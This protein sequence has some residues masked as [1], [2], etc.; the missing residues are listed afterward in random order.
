MRRSSHSWLLRDKCVEHA[1]LTALSDTACPAPCSTWPNLFT[2]TL[3]G[4]PR[5][6]IM[7]DTPMSV[8]VCLL[9]MFIRVTFSVWFFVFYPLMSPL[10]PLIRF[11]V[12][13]DDL[14]VSHLCVIVPTPVPVYLNP[15]LLPLCARLSFVK[16]L[17]LCVLFSVFD[18]WCLDYSPVFLC[19]LTW[20]SFSAY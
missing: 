15:L 10:S 20:I 5:G 12:G 7:F 13:V 3:T 9:C 6:A 19:L 2:F 8:K 17:T 11:R 16:V 4:S 1:N 14:P 18:E